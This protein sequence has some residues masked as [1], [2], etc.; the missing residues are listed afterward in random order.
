ML[1]E[2]ECKRCHDKIERDLQDAMEI[3]ERTEIFYTKKLPVASPE[4]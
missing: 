1:P 4:K 3:I 2:Q